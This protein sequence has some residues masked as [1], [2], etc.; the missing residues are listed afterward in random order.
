MTNVANEYELF[1]KHAIQ[2]AKILHQNHSWSAV[3][4]M[5][6][7]RYGEFEKKYN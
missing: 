2:S 1:K 3:A 6:L 4:D 7:E 5:I